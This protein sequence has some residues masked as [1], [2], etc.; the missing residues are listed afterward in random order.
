MHRV[1]LLLVSSLLILAGSVLGDDWP[2]FRGPN[3]DGISKETGLLK[4][5]PKNLVNDRGG[6]LPNWGYT[7]SPLVDGDNV[8]CT[9]G[10]AKGTLAAL[11]KKTGKVVWRSTGWKDTA[12]YS[13]IVVGTPHKTRQY[14]QMAGE[15]IAGVDAKTGKL[16]WRF[17]RTHRITVP[18]VLPTGNYVYITSGYGVACN[19][20]ELT[21]P[22]EHREVY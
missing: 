9:P 15:S 5:W 2:Q 7:E 14:M 21:S 17:P 6:K 16:M 12:N 11:D 3:R 10:G 19:L 13:S 18:N 22:T 1:R 4:T 20:L 8:I